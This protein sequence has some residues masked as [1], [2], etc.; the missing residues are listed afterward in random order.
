MGRQPLLLQAALLAIRAFGRP[1][2]PTPAK[3][4]LALESTLFVN[5]LTASMWTRYADEHRGLCL[6]FETSAD[7]GVPFN[8]TY[9]DDPVR[10]NFPPDQSTP[11]R[12]LDLMLTKMSRWAEEEEWRIIDI[13]NGPGLHTFAPDLLSGVIFGARMPDAQRSLVRQ[14]LLAGGCRPELLEAQVDTP[15]GRV[16]IIPYRGG[17]G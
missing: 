14:W 12:G 10:L 6:R 1:L 2:K 5:D 4:L 11:Q 9:S 7:F 3:P 16:R 17:V 13:N 15:S 8:V